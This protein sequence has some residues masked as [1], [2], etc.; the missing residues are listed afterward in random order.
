M[1]KQVIRANQLIEIL[2]KNQMI[3]IRELA[4]LLNVSEMTIRRDLELLKDMGAA[5][6]MHG[7]VIYANPELLK[8]DN[9]EYSLIRAGST[10]VKEK[11]RIGIYGASLIEPGDCIILDNGTT[12]EYIADYV[13]VDLRATIL[14]SNLNIIS[15]ICNKPNLTLMFGGGYF[16]ADTYMFESPESISLIK[17]T[18]ASKV[19]VSAAGVHDSLGVTCANNYELATKQAILE[20]GAE[21]I[22]V[23]DSSKFGLVKPCYFADITDFDKI[24][25]DKSLPDYWVNY[26]ADKGISLVML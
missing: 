14:S 13:P 10:H 18:R 8:I 4:S 25:T 15:K 23:L 21:K 16:H 5:V 12:T 9:E 24:I 2:H 20:S 22:L 26:I 6:N 17:R 3:T 11:E 19:F 1:K 7:A